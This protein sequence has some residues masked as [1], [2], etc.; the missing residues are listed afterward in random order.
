MYFSGGYPEIQMI[1]FGGKNAGGEICE[2]AGWAVGFVEIYKYSPIG[3]HVYYK[4]A[5]S[6]VGIF[7]AGRVPK[8]NEECTVIFLVDVKLVDLSIEFKR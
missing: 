8:A 5:P 2:G 4:V 7:L 6:G 1:L 3:F